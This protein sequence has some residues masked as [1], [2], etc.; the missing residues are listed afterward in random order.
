MKRTE[1]A[2][3]WHAATGQLRRRSLVIVSLGAIISFCFFFGSSAYHIGPNLNLDVS[4]QALLD[5]RLAGESVGE[6][7]SVHEECNPVGVCE[8]CTF[9]D[10]KTYPVCE[11][12]GRKQRYECTTILN[13]GKLSLFN[14]LRLRWFP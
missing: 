5:R 6:G 3:E 1:K 14:L 8:M 13:E 11:E 4:M 12:T 7:S 10:Q 9:S 2:E